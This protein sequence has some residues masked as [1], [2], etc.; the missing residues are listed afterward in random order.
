M[1]T[2]ATQVNNGTS[3]PNFDVLGDQ[4]T[5]DGIPGIVQYV[6]VE[7]QRRDSD[8]TIAEADGAYHGLEVDRRGRLK[9]ADLQTIIPLTFT[10][11]INTSI[12]AATDQFG[13]INT[14]ANAAQVAGGCGKIVSASLTDRAK[15]KAALTVILFAVSPTLASTNNGLFDLT[16]ANL[17]AAKL[18]GLIDFPVASYRDSVSNAFAMGTIVGAVNGVLPYVTSGTSSLFAVMQVTTGTPTYASTSDVVVTLN[19]TYT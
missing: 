5:V 4:T 16:D 19:L 9:V 2:V 6:G 1:G 14:I 17:E 13:A 8:A 12:Y 11:V 10:P 7:A 3:G 15:Q 18:V